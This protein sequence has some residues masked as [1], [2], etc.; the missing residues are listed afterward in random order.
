MHCKT[1]KK[2]STA[3]TRCADCHKELT[4]SGLLF[5]DLRRTAVRNMVRA[6]VPEKIAMQV[7]GHLTRLVFD[8]YHIVALADMQNVATKLDALRETN[9]S[10]DPVTVLP[11][12]TTRALNER[13]CFQALICFPQ[14][15]GHGTVCPAG[16]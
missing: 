11:V 14:V 15:Q 13:L 1:C 5:H 3:R 12:R 9:L 7:T 6:G 10:Y 8:R 2:Q 4:Y 16:M